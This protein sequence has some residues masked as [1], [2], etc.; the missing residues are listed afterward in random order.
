MTSKAFVSLHTEEPGNCCKGE[1][2]YP[3]YHR[4]EISRSEKYWLIG[5]M[6]AEFENPAVFPEVRGVVLYVTHYSITTSPV[7]RDSI[8]RGKLFPP[9]VL[10]PGDILRLGV[11]AGPPAVARTGPS[12]GGIC[13][14]C[15]S[16]DDY[17]ERGADGM[18]LCWA[19]FG[20]RVSQ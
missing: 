17:P 7:G 18:V 5:V 2:A 6:G 4:A 15:G 16:F 10:S 11:K 9:R 19:C 14:R 3:G 1:V 13:R 12:Y 20:S 8:Y